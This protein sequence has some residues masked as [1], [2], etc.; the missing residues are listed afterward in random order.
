MA[1]C[2]SRRP[3][4]AALRALPV[5]RPVSKAT[6]HPQR[7]EPAPEVL[8]MLI[9]QQFGRRHQRDLA[10]HLHGMS[11]GERRHQCLAATDIALHQ[12]QHGLRAGEILLDLAQ[13]PLLGRG[14]PERQGGQQ[15]V[16]ERAVGRERP[17][18]IALNAL[19]QELERQLVREQFFE[20]KPALRRMPPVQQLIDGCVRRRPVH[21]T[22][23]VAQRP[24]AASRPAM[25]AAA[26]L[27]GSGPRSDPMPVRPAGAAGPE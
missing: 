17:A 25:S 20:G 26:N 11:R 1:A 23:G 16:F 22:Q 13:H 14:Q 6:G 15:P 2:P 8:R 18:R 21:I 5:C 4:S 24:A 10:L 27:P 3:A 7:L 12:A 9:G 19:P